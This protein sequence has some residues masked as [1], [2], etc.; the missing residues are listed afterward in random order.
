MRKESKR[1]LGILAT[2][3]TVVASVVSVVMEYYNRKKLKALEKRINHL[4]AK[5]EERLL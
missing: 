1:V 4:D 5:V 3:V 2:T